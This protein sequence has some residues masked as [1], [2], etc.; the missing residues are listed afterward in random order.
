MFLIRSEIFNQFFSPFL[1]YE[2]RLNVIEN[3]FFFLFSYLNGFFLLLNDYC[4]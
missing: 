3:L 4:C 1:V 2:P